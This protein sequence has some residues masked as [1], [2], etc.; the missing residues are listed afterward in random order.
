[1]SAPP[2]PSP[3]RPALSAPARALRKLGLVRDI[4]LALHLPLRYEDETRLVP[5]STLR[6]GDL[7]QVEG[8]VIDCRV[9]QRSRRQL[10]VR[11]ADDAGELVLRF[12]NFYGSQQKQLATGRRLRI[13]GEPRGG[14]L[15][16]EMVHPRYRLV[17]GDEALPEAMTP[18]YPTTA[19]LSQLALRK[20]AAQAHGEAMTHLLDA[21]EKRD[22]A[23]I[24][25]VQELGGRANAA[26][27]NLWSQA[28]AKAAAPDAVA[29]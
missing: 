13:F 28:I 23:C 12:L 8:D 26:Q 19:G 21:W 4:D 18:I 10:V 5:M 7:A 1:M 16:D 22:C 14:F 3:A 29:A 25:S 17:G 27:R 20:L 9:E 2:S 11:L 6:D 24:P 15:G